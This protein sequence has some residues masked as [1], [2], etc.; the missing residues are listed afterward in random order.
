MK[1]IVHTRT[2]LC[3][4]PSAYPWGNGIKSVIS[5]VYDI[6]VSTQNILLFPLYSILRSIDNLNFSTGGNQS[7]NQS[8]N[9]PAPVTKVSPTSVSSHTLP[10]RVNQSPEKARGNPGLSQVDSGPAQMSVSQLS[11]VL[12]Q[13]LNRGA[14]QSGPTPGI[15]AAAGA[16]SRAPPPQPPAPPPP[17][18]TNLTLVS[19]YVVYFFINKLLLAVPSYISILAQG[20]L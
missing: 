14:K 8:S 13:T 16:A 4:F 6:I 1:Q 11:L 10:R 18:K 20:Y 3:S 7:S 5:S 15:S 12:G 17:N 9:Q 19:D 2:E